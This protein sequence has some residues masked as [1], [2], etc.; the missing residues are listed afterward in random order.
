MEKSIG[1][2][3]CLGDRE[4]FFFF[5]QEAVNIFEDMYNLHPS[6]A[7]RWKSYFFFFFFSIYV[8]FVVR[9]VIEP[10]FRVVMIK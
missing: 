6:L 3:W 9:L 5:S 10:A 7:G 2:N 4:F 1:E 8:L